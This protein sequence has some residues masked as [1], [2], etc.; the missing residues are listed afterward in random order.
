[1][2]KVTAYSCDYCDKKYMTQ[3][4]C[5][6]H[7]KYCYFDPKNKACASCSNLTNGTFQKGY[8]NCEK[9]IDLSFALRY[10]CKIHNI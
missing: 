1:M 3:S 5:K 6:R 2:K 8:R 9:G 7:E 4:G 10:N